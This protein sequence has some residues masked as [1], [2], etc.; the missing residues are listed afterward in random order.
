MFAERS[1]GGGGQ[2]E[3]ERARGAYACRTGVGKR[4]HLDLLRVR[5]RFVIGQ[6]DRIAFVVV[7]QGAQPTCGI[8][9]YAGNEMPVKVG[10]LKRFDRP[11]GFERLV[12]AVCLSVV[13]IVGIHRDSERAGGVAERGAVKSERVYVASHVASSTKFT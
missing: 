8:V 5:D 4:A 13:D 11:R 1:S 3:L 12:V 10:K 6:I 7:I 2:D 9:F